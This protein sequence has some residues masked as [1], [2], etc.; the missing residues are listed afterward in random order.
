MITLIGGIIGIVFGA[1]ISFA[2]AAVAQG[3]G[4]NWDFVISIGSIF[5]RPRFPSVWVLFSVWRRP[6][7]PPT[8]TRLRR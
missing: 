4:Y 6:D 5:S 7:A 8:L 3:L 1:L 2:V